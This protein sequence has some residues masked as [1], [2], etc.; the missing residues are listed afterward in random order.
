VS[1]RARIVGCV[2]LL[3]L[4]SACTSTPSTTAS[5]G[6]PSTP[7]GPAVP[8]PSPT[9]SAIPP[10]PTPPLPSA[11][12]SGPGAFVVTWSG[13]TFVNTT[14]PAAHPTATCYSGSASASLPTIGRVVLARTVEAGDGTAIAPSGCVD[15]L[16]DGTITSSTG[17][18]TF[19]AAGLLCG[20]A[21]TYTV[22][23][24]K[25]AGSMGGYMIEAQIVN[26]SVS[27]TWS[28]QIAPAP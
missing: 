15:A 16:T 23:A 17:T 1:R 2:L 7:A 27:E 10:S 4:V 18:L 12:F 21:S 20:R 14:C 3:G 9:P 25:G 24:S 22:T 19:H 11:G 8:G 13:T 5:G 26:D 6:H 28:G